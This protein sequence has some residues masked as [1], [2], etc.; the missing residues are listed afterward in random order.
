MSQEVVNN[1]IGKAATDTDFR[2][3][4]RDNPDQALKGFDLTEE[5]KDS[6]RKMNFESLDKFSGDLDDRISKKIRHVSVG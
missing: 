1:I 6:L 5:E 3:L 2:Q 4:L